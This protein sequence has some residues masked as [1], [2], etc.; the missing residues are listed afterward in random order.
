MHPANQFAAFKTS[1]RS[2]HGIA[3]I[4]ARFGVPPTVAGNG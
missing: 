4:T 1:G 3:D 2:D